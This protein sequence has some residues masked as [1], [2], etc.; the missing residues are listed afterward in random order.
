MTRSLEFSWYSW[1]FHCTPKGFGI[2]R[3]HLFLV[4][5]DLIGSYKIRDMIL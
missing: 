3:I 1:D 2:Q 5:S 4:A